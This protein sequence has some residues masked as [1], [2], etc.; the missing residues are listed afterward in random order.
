MGRSMR[1]IAKVM[2]GFQEGVLQVVKICGEVESEWKSTMQLSGDARCVLLQEEPH[3]SSFLYLLS[4]CLV[5]QHSYVAT[6]LILLRSI[7]PFNIAKLWHG[8]LIVEAATE[9]LLF[10]SQ[11]PVTFSWLSVNHRTTSRQTIRTIED[12]YG[13]TLL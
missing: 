9:C 8:S 1:L 2:Q 7:P 6:G 3:S 4:I 11:P 13:F 12:S 5:G 10:T